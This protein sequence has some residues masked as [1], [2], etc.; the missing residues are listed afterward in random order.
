MPPAPSSSSA[1]KKNLLRPILVP[2]ILFLA[3]GLLA[4]LFLK[5]SKPS[6][7][8]QRETQR[9]RVLQRIQIAGGWDALEKE[10]IALAEENKNGL[11]HWGKWPD[12][13]AILPPA[14]AALEPKEIKFRP[15][16]SRDTS[17]HPSEV[18]IIQIKIFGTHATGNRARPYY[19]LEVISGPGGETY[20]PRPKRG[21]LGN[22]HKDYRNITDRIYEIY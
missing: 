7:T 3:V 10:C 21:A 14:I 4:L 16:E 1:P 11:L 17:N 2:A 5:F 19:G 9:K 6:I 22:G 15:Y 18:P 20:K 13:Q 12:N 8:A